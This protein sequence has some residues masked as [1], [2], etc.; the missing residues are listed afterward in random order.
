M[1]A[2]LNLLVHSIDQELFNIWKN[3]KSSKNLDRKKQKLSKLSLNTSF[4]CLRKESKNVNGNIGY[5]P[6]EGR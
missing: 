3:E 5:K 2:V 1:R 6:V 4:L